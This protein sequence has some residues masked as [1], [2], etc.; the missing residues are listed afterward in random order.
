MSIGKD[1]SEKGFFNIYKPTFNFKIK[2]GLNLMNKTSLSQYSYPSGTFEVEVDITSTITNPWGIF[3][4]SGNIYV[5]NSGGTIY[6]VNVNFPYTQTLFN[7]SG[8][9]I[10]GASQVPSCCDTNLN[11]PPTPTPTA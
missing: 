7:N 5:C 8:I 11:L 4:D 9:S 10:G 1:S 2:D 3:I 6:N